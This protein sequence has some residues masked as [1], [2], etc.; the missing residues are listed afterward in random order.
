MMV[1][2]LA[3]PRPRRCPFGVAL[4]LSCASL[5]CRLP[6]P[7]RRTPTRDRQLCGPPTP[8]TIDNNQPPMNHQ[9]PWP[10]STKPQ[11]LYPIAPDPNG[12]A[13]HQL[14][15]VLILSSLSLI[16]IR[17]H[18][19]SGFSNSFHHFHFYLIL[20]FSFLHLSS[21]HFLFYF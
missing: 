21:L 18:K 5:P 19:I 2:A 20:H 16:N 4:A 12:N 8:P 15:N 11:S 13:K 6:C 1:C 14:L 7:E 3:P 9:L 17:Y 10:N